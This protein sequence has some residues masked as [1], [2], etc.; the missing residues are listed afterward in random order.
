MGTKRAGLLLALAAWAGTAAAQGLSLRIESRPSWSGAGLQLVDA[1][2]GE[3]ALSPQALG[4]PA[5][6]ELQ[7]VARD[8]AGRVLYTT[9][10]RDPRVLQAEAFDPASG[11]IIAARRVQLD[12]AQ[13]ELRLPDDRRLASIEITPWRDTGAGPKRGA[14]V[15]RFGLAD[16]ERGLRARQQLRGMAK[17]TL[18]SELLHASGPSSGRFDIVLVGDGYTSAEMAKWRSDA[19]RVASGLLADPLFAAHAQAINI[20]RVDV[21]SAQSGIDDLTYGVYRNTALGMSIGCYNTERLVCAD[22][23][24]VYAAIAPVTPAD[25]RDVIVAIANTTRYGGA[26]GGIATMTMHASA[27]ELALHEIGH[28]AFNLADEYDY[29]SC[30]NASEPGEPNVSRQYQRTTLKWRDLIAPST[31]LPTPTGRHPNGTVGAFTG[32][33]YCTAGIY[34]PTENSRM[35]TLGQPWH[36]VNE[37][38]A[39]AVIASHYR[40]D[41]AG[42]VVVSGSLAGTNA[43]ADHPSPY[44]YSA[45]GGMITATLSGPANADFELFLYRWNGSAWTVVARSESPTSSEAIQYTAPAGYFIVQVRSYS[46]SGSYTLRYHLP[47]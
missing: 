2:R 46:G 15:A 41:G 10:V 39:A 12:A 26:G 25:G 20:R 3:F 18:G 28:T 14:E 44:H 35:R 36:A 6:G 22:S 11:A 47:Q 16:I 4:D 32:G 34:R 27:I 24:L 42:E 21:T 43:S 40:A 17:A 19:Q 37:R 45:N 8:K 7:V 30:Y 23:N 9:R 13:F 29:G 5:G 38:R 31:P 1:E 33:R